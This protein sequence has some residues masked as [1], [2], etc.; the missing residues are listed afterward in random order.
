MANHNLPTLT[1]TYADF[2]TEM[3]ARMDDISIGFDP[4]LTA[5]TNQAT[6]TIRW[7]AASNK[8][9]KWSGTAW[10]NLSNSYAINISGSAAT[11]TTATTASTLAVAR[12]INGVAFDGSAAISVNLVNSLTINN[13]GSGVA[14]GSTFNGGSAITISYNSVGAPSTAGTNATGTWP[15]SITGN[16]ATATTAGSVTNGVY[17]TGDQTIAGTKTFSSNIVGNLTG[18]VTGNAS[19]A[20]TA[21]NTRKGGGEKISNL[22]NG[23]L[24]MVN[25]TS[26]I[27][28]T[29]NGYKALEKNTVGSGN[30][31]FGA[32][33]LIANWGGSD[34]TAVGVTS[35]YSNTT[36]GS[37]TAIGD[38]AMYSNTDGDDNTAVG[39]YALRA[40]TTARGNTAVGRYAL[41]SNN[42]GFD[43][44]AVGRAALSNL[45]GYNFRNTAIGA[46]ALLN[47]SSMSSNNTAVGADA[48]KSITLGFG[49]CTGLGFN[50]QVTAGDQ[51]QL[52]SSST[53]TYVYGTVQNRS[54]LRDKA[55][56]R[57]TTLGLSFIN[58]LRPVD[59]KWDMREDY[60]P[61]APKLEEDATAEQI[62]A[63]KAATQV[64]LEAV[65][66]DNLVHD[67]SKKR[68]RYHHGLIAQEVKEVIDQQ[69]IDFGGYQD[70][71]L[72]GG[73]DVLSIGYDELIAPLIKA[74]QELTARV[75]QLEQSVVT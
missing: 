67:G 27:Y 52:G 20:T 2:V 70:H 7:V 53:T 59:Y 65:K 61:A 29:A 35:L 26:G 25:N 69:G 58:A 63:H 13:S 72:S 28:N 68:N 48:L 46:D 62:A 54:D 47:V 16:A 51:V 36:G 18:N 34:N 39:Q 57:D 5:V 24:A 45:T 10:G 30:T 11:A 74:V 12:N 56:V 38:Q 15:I 1:S 23:D 64:W 50:A 60:R 22:A 21:Q 55:D 75:K 31:A 42:T 6:G 8:W 32:F 71:K 37:N 40:N 44:T 49:G 9:E 73:N 19:T 43:N 14:S 4:A 17:T 66:Q 41:S 33:S 3:D